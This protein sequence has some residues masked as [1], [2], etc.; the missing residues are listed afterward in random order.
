MSWEREYFAC[1]NERVWLVNS[2]NCLRDR[3]NESMSF[4]QLTGQQSRTVTTARD[5]FAPAQGPFI[6]EH[7]TDLRNSV[8]K[9]DKARKG[10]YSLHATS[11]I[12]IIIRKLEAQGGQ[13]RSTKAISLK[14]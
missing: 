10:H 13:R 7:G 11:S 9:V 1:T 8:D 6:S 4:G 14:C 3:G 12:M 5:A 2:Q